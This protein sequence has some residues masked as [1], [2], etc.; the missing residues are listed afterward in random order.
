[1]N[2]SLQNTQFGQA[3]AGLQRRWLVGQLALTLTMAALFNFIAALFSVI[4]IA[5]LFEPSTVEEITILPGII[6]LLMMLGMVATIARQGL[7]FKALSTIL[8]LIAVAVAVAVA[9]LS[10]Y[11]AWR[12]L[13]GD[14]KFSVVRGLCLGHW[15]CGAVPPLPGLI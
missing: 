2:A 8:G 10:G 11:V 1:V 4:F 12:A 5:L 3:R 9:G 6:V 13:K 15:R 14:D 7:T